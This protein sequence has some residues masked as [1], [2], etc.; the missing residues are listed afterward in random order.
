MRRFLTL[1]LVAA[2]VLGT[3]GCGANAPTDGETA[4]VISGEAQPPEPAAAPEP[5]VL[6]EEPS[7]GME[8]VLDFLGKVVELHTQP[9]VSP[10][11]ER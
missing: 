1:L 7:S 5:T 10:E 8:S 3:A 9:W 11:P 4:A 2:L 6:P